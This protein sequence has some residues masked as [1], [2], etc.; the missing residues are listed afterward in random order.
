MRN[1]KIKLMLA[2]FLLLTLILLLIGTITSA[3]RQDRINNSIYI[4]LTRDSA[5]KKFSDG[6]AKNYDELQE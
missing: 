5:A 6:G 4:S 1:L 2:I 3:T